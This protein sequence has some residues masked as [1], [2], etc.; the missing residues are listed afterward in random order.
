MASTYLNYDFYIK[1][2]IFGTKW[3][4]MNFRMTCGD[5]EHS[6]YASNVN[7]IR[8]NIYIFFRI[9]RILREKHWLLRSGS[10]IL[11][12]FFLES[13]EELFY[14]KIR[15]TNNQLGVAWLQKKMYIP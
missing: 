1:L 10:L 4:V 2:L 3:L 6:G 5:W 8:Q 13:D 7:F 15:K 9:L 12:L 14:K 11:F